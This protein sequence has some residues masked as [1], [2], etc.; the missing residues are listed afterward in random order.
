MGAA[1]IVSCNWTCTVCRTFCYWISIDPRDPETPFFLGSLAISPKAT[2]KG[3]AWVWL[4][5]AGIQHGAKQ[6]VSGTSG[7]AF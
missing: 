1:P 7:I 2:G 5:V 3:A 6:N 4:L